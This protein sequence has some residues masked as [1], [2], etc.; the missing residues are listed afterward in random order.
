MLKD[1][2][3]RGEERWYRVGNPKIQAC[4]K[5]AK[6]ATLSS[7]LHPRRRLSQIFHYRQPSTA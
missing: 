3:I 1:L 7:P 5:K 6:P 2:N 4:W